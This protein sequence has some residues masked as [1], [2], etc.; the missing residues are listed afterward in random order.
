MGAP[1]L[2]IDGVEFRDL[3]KNGKLDVYE[4]PRRPIEERIA[5]LLAQMTLEEKVGLFF[6]TI[7]GVN[8]NGTLEPHGFLRGETLTELV[9]E[10]FINHFNVHALP[11]PRMAVAWHNA[12]QELAES[13]RLGIPVTISSDPR[14][15]FAQNPLTSFRASDFSQWPEPIGLGAT[16]DEQL[17]EEF[18]NIARQEYCAVGIRVA[19]HPM[20]DLATEPRW[21]RINGTFG[22][23]AELSAK[24]TAAYIRGFQGKELGPESVACMTKHFPGGGP[25][26]DGEDPHFP[27]GREQVYPGNNFEYHL[28]PFKA[29]FEAG[30]AQIMPYYGMPIETEMEEVGFG[31]NRGVIT[32]MLRKRFG[33]DGVVCGDWGLLTDANIMGKNFPARAWGVEHLSVPER[34]KKAIDA[35]LDQF[36][37]ESCTHILLE[38]VRSGAISEERIDES[39]VRLLRDKFRLGLFDNP[40]ID[41]DKA[42]ETLSRSD[43][44]EAGALAQ[45]KSI[46]LL[47]K[48]QQEN[49]PL[50]PIRNRPK[51]Y[52]EGVAPEALA[53]YAELASSPDEADL[54]IVRV[55]TPFEPRDEFFLEAMF[56]AGHLDFK[57]E[58]LAHLVGLCEKLPT[59]VAVM[60]ERPA[61]LPEIAAKAAGLLGEFGASDDAL[62][63]I[64]FG[65]FNPSAKLPFE[66]PSSMEAVEA[67]YADL[68]YDSRDPLFPFGFGLSY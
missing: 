39:V 53:D 14:H 15:S 57:G 9:S 32:D 58:Q 5:D 66:L 46:V 34:T 24:L 30:T 64:I 40:Y 48:G 4:D 47:K 35:G 22:E 45:R 42:V 55:N 52:L 49:E 67:Q 63:D 36:G 6:H 11:E 7:A 26:K 68:P 61:V 60:L 51:V 18:G 59:I 2:V 27:Y 54:A 8:P 29:A 44:R 33:F 20:A 19:L 38:L 17:V 28:I 21:G 41:A 12:L 1:R 10:R 13:T 37:G 23:D 62:L 3:N 50:L 25:Q 31:F 16:A 43:F 65:R 56:H